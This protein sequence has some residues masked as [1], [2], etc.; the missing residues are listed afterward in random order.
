MVSRVGTLL[1]SRDTR[2]RGNRSNVVRFPVTGRDPTDGAVRTPTRVLGA[3]FP[4]FSAAARGV[5]SDGIV[6]LPATRPAG[7]GRSTSRPNRAAEAVAGDRGT[8]FVAAL[9]LATDQALLEIGSGNGE[10][11]IALARRVRTLDGL[12]RVPARADY[13]RERATREGLCNTRF[14]AGGDDC[15]LPYA[16]AGFDGVVIDRTLERWTGD[17][18]LA[19]LL[20]AEVRRV[21]KPGGFL[22]LNGRNRFALARVADGPAPDRSEHL[23]SRPRLKLLLREAG[24]RRIDSYWSLPEGQMSSALIP[25]DSDGLRRARARN[26]PIPSGLAQTLL[27]ASLLRFFAP[28]LTFLA[29]R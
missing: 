11:A 1:N 15:R 19:R 13:C 22:Y 25:F 28:E 27:P 23:L 29:Y 10:L 26:A 8:D 2:G 12:E 17:V 21:L 20:L 9:P 24:F 14:T 3:I 5:W 16:D 6:L 7:G 4:P 18:A